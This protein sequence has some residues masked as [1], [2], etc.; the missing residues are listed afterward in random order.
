MLPCI[1]TAEVTGMLGWFRKQ[2][3][4]SGFDHPLTREQLIQVGRLLVVDDE[5]LLLIDELKKEGFAVDQDRTGNDL[6]NLESQIYDLAIIDYY[7]VGQRLGTSQGLDLIRHIRRVSPRTRVIA[8]TA[9]SLDANESDFFRLSHAVLPKDLGLGDSLALIEG[10]LRKAFAK[11]HLFE[12]L[13]A[14]LNV[15]DEQERARL[16]QALIKALSKGD[17]ASFKEVLIEMAGQAGA[18]AVEIIIMK[19]FSA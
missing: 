19:L 1:K 6:H 12:A 4:L 9:R 8:S 13:I 2:K 7:G 10:E 5:K 11:E 3:N 16:Q 15:S 18:K 14:K 17:D